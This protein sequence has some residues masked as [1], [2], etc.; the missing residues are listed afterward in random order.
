MTTFLRD[1]NRVGTP[2]LFI[3]NVIFQPRVPNQITS[4]SIN[5]VI[6]HFNSI[7]FNAYLLYNLVFIFIMRYLMILW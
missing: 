6:I 3:S 1:V 2:S 7:P 4:L 5:D